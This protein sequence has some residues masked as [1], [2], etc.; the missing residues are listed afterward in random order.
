MLYRGI[1]LPGRPDPENVRKLDVLPL[2][3]I[4]RMQRVGVAIDREWL[5]DLSTRIESRKVELRKDIAFYIPADRLDEFVGASD[6]DI[7]INVDSAPQIARLLYD[8]LG[9]GWGKQLK[10]T[11]SGDRLSKPMGTPGFTEVYDGSNHDGEPVHIEG[12]KTLT[13]GE[14]TDLTVDTPVNAAF[15]KEGP[16]YNAA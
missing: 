11:K 14:V 4:R 12:T 2:A 1:T 10:K 13:A 7:S 3:Q 16:G 9:V 6:D 15:Y 5:W 8:M